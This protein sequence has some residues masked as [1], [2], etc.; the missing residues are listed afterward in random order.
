VLLPSYLVSNFALPKVEAGFI[1]GVFIVIA[2][3]IRPIGGLLADKFNP[4]FLLILVFSL[5]GIASVVVAVASQF[6]VF[7][8]AI[9]V[10][11]LCSGIGNGVVFKLVPLLAKEQIGTANGIV[12]AT[13]SFGGFF[14]PL[15]IAF[16]VS[17]FNS[18]SLGFAFFTVL[19][20]VC[21]SIIIVNYKRFQTLI[22]EEGA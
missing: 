6:I 9:M 1:T 12:A 15:I 7:V 20:L 4:Y 11:S 3:L 22:V 5:L 10:I 16:I 21:L 17:M 18:H 13:G 14:P 19:A 2:T 8:V